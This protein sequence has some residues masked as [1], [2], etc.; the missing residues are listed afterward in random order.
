MRAVAVRDSDD[1]ADIALG[2]NFQVSLLAMRANVIF[3]QTCAQTI[4]R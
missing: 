4:R 2:S 1:P 3:D